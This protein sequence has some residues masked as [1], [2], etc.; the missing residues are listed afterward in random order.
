M[1]ILVTLCLLAAAVAPSS[2]CGI[3]THTEVGYR[4]LEYLG[5]AEEVVLTTQLRSNKW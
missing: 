1:Q 3:S 4:A 5:Y 2:G